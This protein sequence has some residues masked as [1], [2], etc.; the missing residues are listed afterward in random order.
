M[1][2]KSAPATTRSRPAATMRTVRAGGL[3]VVEAAN[4]FARRLLNRPAAV[5]GSLVRL[6]VTMVNSQCQRPPSGLREILY[7]PLTDSFPGRSLAHDSA[8]RVARSTCV[9]RHVAPGRLGRRP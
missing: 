4:S 7:G 1:A 5:P 8:G 9:Q 6:D 2:N 3:R